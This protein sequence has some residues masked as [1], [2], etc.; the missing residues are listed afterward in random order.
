ME[1]NI[2]LPGNSVCSYLEY[3]ENKHSNTCSVGG[4]S[5]LVVDMTAW[6]FFAAIFFTDERPSYVKPTPWVTEAECRLEEASVIEG[7]KDLAANDPSVIIWQTWCL[8]VDLGH[9]A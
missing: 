4:T 8:P 2:V 6:V 3:Q 1:R 7:L 5:L 9:G